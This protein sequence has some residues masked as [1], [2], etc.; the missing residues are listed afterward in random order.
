MRD[1]LPWLLPI[2]VFAT[3]ACGSAASGLAECPSGAPSACATDRAACTGG[4]GAAC[5]QLGLRFERGD[6]VVR[7][8]AAADAYY[9]RACDHRSV[10][11]CANAGF[12]ALRG[13][14]GP[15]ALATART[16]LEVGCAGDLAGWPPD[17]ST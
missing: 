7:N 8:L 15:T 10:V 11:G 16:R 1:R 17:P 6:D 14:G 12:L 9:A 13:F 5:N 4:D 2:V 3:G